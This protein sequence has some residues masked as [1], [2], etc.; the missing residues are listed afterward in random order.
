MLAMSPPVSSNIQP[1]LA[2]WTNPAPEPDPRETELLSGVGYSMRNL[3]SMV[4]RVAA[5]SS[6]VLLSGETGT[7]KTRMARLIHDLSPRRDQPFLVVNCGA[8]SASL[9]ESEMFGHIRGA[10]TG[11][12]RDRVGKFADA[13]TGTLFLD[14]ID[15]LPPSLQ[16][17]LLRAVEDR[18]FEAVGSNKTMEVRARLIVASNRDLAH[19]VA[20]E[21][22]RG[23][24]YYRLNVVG[25][26]LPPLRE[27]PE[28]V[29]ALA[30]RFLEQLAIQCGRRLRGFSTAAMLCLESHPWPGNVRELRNVIE[31]AVVLSGGDHIGVEDLPA[32]LRGDRPVEVEQPRVSSLSE[33][34]IV[35]NSRSLVAIREGAEQERILQALAKH[36]N[37]RVQTAK[38]LGVSRM[39]LYKKLHKYGL[40]GNGTE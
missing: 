36:G 34:A 18:V 31:R 38:D 11:A 25:F 10:F 17:K 19:E 7:G 13:G 2:A 29:S 15:S 33:P 5:M 3:A 30:N 23:D 21:R 12:D 39:T 26:T 22:F 27:R 4:R 6:T 35:P 24:L 9:I 32:S 16:A 40:M 1:H 8:L 14:E 28:V 20:C 37:N